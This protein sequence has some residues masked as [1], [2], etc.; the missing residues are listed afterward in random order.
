MAMQTGDIVKYK[1]ELPDERKQ[2]ESGIL[3]RVVW[4]DRDRAMIEAVCVNLV[5]YPTY[6]VRLDDIEQVKQ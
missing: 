1:N 6:I 4:V 5:F 3:L 2:R